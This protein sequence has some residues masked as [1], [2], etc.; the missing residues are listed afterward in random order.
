M[1][2][3]DDF[4]ALSAAI[5]A[6]PMLVQGPG[7]NTSLKAGGRMTIKASGTRLADA[8]DGT[9]F[10]EVDLA[11]A[12]A[13]VAAGREPVA[14]P[15]APRR[16]SIETGFHAAIPWPIVVHHHSVRALAHLIAPEGRAAAM[17]KLADLAPVFVPY[18]R[19]GGP[20]TARIVAAGRLDAHL[21]LLANHGV[22]IAGDTVGDVGGL[23][24][25]VERRLDLPVCA[26][27]APPGPAAPEVW[28]VRLGA[29]ALGHAPIA[30]LARAG[31]YWPDHVVFLGP[32][33][34]ADGPVRLREGAA[35]LL[36]ADASEAAGEMLDC[37]A[38][39]LSRL[40][41]GWH[42][43]PIG[44]KAEAALA[45]WNAEAYRRTQ[46]QAGNAG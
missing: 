20:L 22:I 10:V 28:R 13:A 12:R 3:P 11:A 4:L 21:W 19:P 24:R 39:V 44:S 30:R 36:R 17:D 31:S 33:I 40:P 41:E 6:D 18:A 38:A 35:P 42:P 2:L 14:A 15:G 1:T 27:P 34:A 37:L 46:A 23:L 16:A 45:G 43:E 5:G 32:G 8:R 9:I 7:G 26:A 29:G 25:E